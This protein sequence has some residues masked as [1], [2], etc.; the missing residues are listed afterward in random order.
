MQLYIH[1]FR[2]KKGKPV[3]NSLKIVFNAK[4]LKPY[5]CVKSVLI[6]IYSGRYSVQMRTNWGQSNSE[7]G[8]FLRSESVYTRP[9]GIAIL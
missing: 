3:S 6:R 5:Y 4:N 7:Y 1:D 8:N 9:P 2:K